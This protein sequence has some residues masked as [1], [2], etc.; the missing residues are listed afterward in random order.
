V[1]ETLKPEI[2]IQAIAAIYPT[3]ASLVT[4]STNQAFVTEDHLPKGK[5]PLYSS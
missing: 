5:Q 3:K 4:Q 1:A 2:I